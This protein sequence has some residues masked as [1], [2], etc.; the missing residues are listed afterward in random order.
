VKGTIHWV[1]A[2]HA[3]EAAIRLFGHLFSVPDPDHEKACQDY[4]SLI[5]PNSLESVRGCQVERAL[6]GAGVGQRFQF[7]RQGYFCVDCD[8][9]SQALVLNRIVALRDSWSKIEH[10]QTQDRR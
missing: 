5:N 2:A 10:G 7:E 8:S 1:S 4:R 3:L 9:T 6:Q